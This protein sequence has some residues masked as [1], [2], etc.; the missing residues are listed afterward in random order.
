MKKLIGFL[1]LCFV[2]SCTA[3]DKGLFDPVK[4]SNV[5][6]TNSSQDNGVCVD[7]PHQDDGCGSWSCAWFC[8]TWQG[9]LFCHQECYCTDW[10]PIVDVPI[11]VSSMPPIPCE[12]CHAEAMPLS[13]SYEHL[14]FQLQNW[15]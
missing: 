9:R 8:D 2:V 13:T 6:V 10:D 12:Q 7:C 14:K 4:D 5:A 11:E 3:D 1:V 15:L